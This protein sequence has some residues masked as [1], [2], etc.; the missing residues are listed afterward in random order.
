MYA[1]SC[2][3]AMCT[4]LE[5]LSQSNTEPPHPPSV[6]QVFR[7]KDTTFVTLLDD[8]RYGRNI[9]VG[10]RIRGVRLGCLLAAPTQ[11]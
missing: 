2:R 3:H 5:A 10:G 1:C 9:Q 8:V 7:Q 6:T 4:R 11:P